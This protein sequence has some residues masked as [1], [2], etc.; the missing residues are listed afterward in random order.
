MDAARW[1]KLSPLL[2]ALLELEPEARVRRLQELREED[3]A[4]ADE[5]ESLI[6]LE[7]EDFLAEPLMA[8]LAGVSTGSEVGPYRLEGLLGEGGMGQVWLALRADGLY[9]RRVAL[10]LLRPGLTSND[11]RLRFTREREILARLAHPNIARLLDA[12][13]SGDGLPYLALEYVDGTPITDYCREHHI[14]LERR[15]HMFRQICEAVSHAHA[16]LIVHRDL[17]PSNILVTPAGEVRLLDF[18]IAKLLDGETPAPEQTGTGMR[19]FTLHYAAPEQIRG[20]PV[21]TMTD[22]YSLGVV[23]YELLTDRKPYRLKRHSD[24][25][26]EEAILTADPV[27][28]SLGVQ[29]ETANGDDRLTL[30]RRARALSGDLDNIVLRTMAKRPEQRYPSV[31]ALSQDIGRYQAGRPV[32]ARP[33]SIGYRLRK[34]VR[35]HRWALATGTL[36][37]LVLTTALTMIAWQARQAVAEAGRAQAMQDFMIGLFET[38]GGGREDE[39]LDLHRLLDDAVERGNL[40]LARE[41]RA[42]AELFGV[43]ARL[44]IT[45]GEYAEASALLERQARIIEVTPGIPT[46]LRLES[47]AQ[48][49]RVMRMVGQPEACIELMQ[50]ALALARREQA[51]LPPQVADFQTQLGRCRRVTGERQVARQLFER[52]LALR[53]EMGS[54]EVGTVENLMDLAGLQAD[55]GELEPALAGFEQARAQLETRVGGRHALQIG[56]GR[57]IAAL[58]RALGRPGRAQRAMDDALQVALEV[59]GPAHVVTLDLRRRLVD[60]Y[61]DDSRFAEAETQW[62]D[63]QHQRARRLGQDR[64][65]QDHPDL[66]E[67]HAALGR[68]AW[69]RNELAAALAS[70]HEALRISRTGQDPARTADVLFKLGEVLHAAGR[71]REALPLLREAMALRRRE[72][73]LDVA[74]LGE[75]ERVLGEVEIAL[76]RREAGLARLQQSFAV[77]QRHLGPDHADTLRSEVSLLHLRASTGDVD[78]LRRLEAIARGEDVAGRRH[79]R[80]TIGWQAGVHAA[81]ARCRTTGQ[82]GAMQILQTLA[83]TLAAAQPDG[84]ALTREVAAVRQECAGSGTRTR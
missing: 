3:T 45:L 42:R 59:H 44:R 67:G 43:I 17:K 69:E 82:A 16:N 5:L 72:P 38:A 36:V 54:D 1:Q 33:Q 6:A 75:V 24:A 63:I 34:Y 39:P 31:E 4:L 58:Q 29:R 46:S 20:E 62:L 65:G 26:W 28:P 76:D 13:V 22:V 7:R 14:A 2:D 78:A 19:A 21:T 83:E 52:S 81:E 8:P 50:P 64:L 80:R 37:T 41:P 10:K 35:R 66:I 23:L 40:Q 49:G 32:Q 11:L 77:L 47:I 68:I 84:S 18:G 53:R 70:L 61:L 27:R 25:E 57:E 15:L 12:G 51:Q 56:I 60:L 71:D 79:P 74:R 73:A 55:A 48:R 30:R 9:Q